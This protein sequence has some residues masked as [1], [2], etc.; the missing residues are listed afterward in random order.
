MCRTANWSALTPASGPANR[1]HSTSW[2]EPTS[3][4]TD[5]P[6]LTADNPEKKMGLTGS[7]TATMLFDDVRVPVANE[8]TTGPGDDSGFSDVGAWLGVDVGGVV[9]HGNSR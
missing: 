1:R 4:S 5:T 3:G 7:T 8:V 6:G 9:A 2:S